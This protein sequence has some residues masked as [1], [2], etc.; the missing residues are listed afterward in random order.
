MEI[1]V[2]PE[3]LVE[4][5]LDEV[6]G[7][8]ITSRGTGNMRVKILE[9]ESFELYGLYTIVSGDYLFTLQG[10]INKPFELI[11]GGT[12]LWSGDLY[13]AEVNLQA[14]YSVNTD[15]KGW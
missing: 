1:E 5:I 6:M 3:A 13:E 15:L 4:L 10:I 11:P 7:D 8:I 2:L 9:D 12:I 14:K